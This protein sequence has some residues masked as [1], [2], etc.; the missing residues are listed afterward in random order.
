MA[1]VLWVQNLWIEFYGVMSISA[2]LKK[3]GHESDIVFDNKEEVVDYIRRS[4]PDAI[5]FSCM[6]VQ[7]KWA[8][9]MSSYIKQQGIDTPIVV[10]GIHAT[11]YPEDA[12]SHP[13]MDVVCLNEGEHP[14][15]EFMNALE[16]G[17]DYSTIQNLW[18]RKNSE[19][20]KNATRAKL[21]AQE[22]DAL[23]LADRELYKKYEHF[24]K[25]PFEIFVGSR[26]CPF[27][28]SFCEVPTI[29]KMY[30]GKSVYYR[31]PVKFVDE[32]ED[33][34][35]RGLLA[36]KLVMFTDSTFNSHKKWFLKFLEEYRR[37]INLPFSCN[38]RV[39]LVDET[40][41]RALAESGCDNV[42][43]GVE[44]G[45]FDIRDRILD[46][47]L[48]DEQIYKTADL[49]HKYKIPFVTF[50]LFACPD[51]TYEQAWKT[52]RVN[53]R[54]RPASLG[55]YVFILFP[56][57]RAT[58]YAIEK[59]LLQRDD[60]D[61]L[62]EHPYNIHLSLLA[63]HPDKN[64]DAVKISNLHKFAILVI[65]MPFLEP[66]VRLL[67]KLPP[68][69]VFSTIY[70][71]SQAWEWRKW[72][73]KTTFR[74]LLYEGILNYQALVETHGEKKS[75][76]RRISLALNSRVKKKRGNNSGTARD[77]GILESFP[78]RRLAEK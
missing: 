55:V 4:R 19:V 48:T 60:L 45:D 25:Y 5:A 69:N 23:P 62:D 72:S 64:R 28:C 65:R 37:R 58:E 30:G 41:V 11:M 22:L 18:V 67:V 20:V 70:A 39:D 63:A 6:S 71:V 54:I 17:R 15:L 68:L 10:G 76:L 12:I 53:Q 40:Q 78:E 34:K 27:R 16:E 51:E 50:N 47:H 49:L 14:M 43:F 3:N 36:G 31:D 38:L 21:L 1:K 52:I 33:L 75:I 44:A 66:L 26:G 7:W 8:K 9:E 29:N 42:R 57:I 77:I 59:G 46:K 73:T 56:G 24:R 35:N 61:L 2:L 13:A 32:I 74:R